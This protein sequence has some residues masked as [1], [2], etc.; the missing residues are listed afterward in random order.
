MSMKIVYSFILFTFFSCLSC[1]YAQD[2]NALTAS[3]QEKIVPVQTGSKSYEAKLEVIYP[4]ALRYGYDEIDQ[5]GNRTVYKYE[6]NLA[7]I[8][9]YAVREQTQKDAIYVVLAARNKQKLIKVYKDDEVQPYSNEVSIIAKDIESAREIS[10]LVKK[11]IPPAEKEASSRLKVSGYDA[12]MS[13]LS[14]NVKD[15]T[16]G[17]KKAAQSM[18]SGEKPG[19]V[20]LKQTE[21]DGKT[22]TEEIYTFNLADLNV[23]TV[24]FKITGNKFGIALETI[25]KAK[26]MALRKNNEVKPYVNELVIYTNSVDEARDLKTVLSMMIPQAVEKVKAS[27]KPVASEK[28]GLERIKSLTT[29]ISI[30]TK[31]IGQVLVADCYCTITQTESDP[32]STEV[33]VYKF[34]WLDLNPNG[35]QIDVMADKLFIG[36]E[37]ND[38]KKVI[39]V[40]KNDKFSGYESGLKLYMPDV[41]NARMVKATLDKVIEKCKANYKEPFA[42]DAAAMVTWLRNNIKDVTLE[43]VT[44]NQALEQVEEGKNDKLKFTSRQLNA[45]GTGAEE[46]YEFNLA[47]INPLSIQVVVKGKWLYVSVES[48]FKNKIFKY[49]KD[50]KIQPYANKIEFAVADTEQARN[51]IT[52]LKKTVGLLKAK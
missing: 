23:N 3:I 42:P 52:A 48:D 37:A 16:W 51:T 34:N 24:N 28:E 19:V 29:D 8:D 6:F 41:E 38:K 1:A 27:I 46:V 20:T 4:G 7:D 39:M 12:M 11:A 15:V 13:W 43:D 49:Y 21:S 45:K 50:G 10:A 14:G 33:N 2:L 22:A 31:K 18:S 30:G 36:L 5:K 35:S 32:K 40:S 9:P 26:Y 44:Q 25:G 47:D 17:T